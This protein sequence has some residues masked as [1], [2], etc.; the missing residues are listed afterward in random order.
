MTR[1]MNPGEIYCFWTQK[2]A[3]TEEK[4]VQRSFQNSFLVCGTFQLISSASVEVTAQ[5]VLTE[6]YTECTSMFHDPVP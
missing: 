4:N 1:S 6:S 2:T 3:F 5:P